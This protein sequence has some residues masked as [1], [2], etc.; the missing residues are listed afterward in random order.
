MPGARARNH[1]G[2]RGVGPGA[3]GAGR[4]RRRLLPFGRCEHRG[5]LRFIM[6][7]MFHYVYYVSFMFTMFQYV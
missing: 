5:L 4:R 7:T 1:P 6:F 2:G 3:C